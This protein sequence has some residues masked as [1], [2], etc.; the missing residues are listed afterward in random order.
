MNAFDSSSRSFTDKRT[1]MEQRSPRPSRLRPYFRKRFLVYAGVPLAVLA[2]LFAMRVYHPMASITVFTFEGYLTPELKAKFQREH[3]VRVI[4]RTFPSNQDMMAHLKVSWGEYDVVT[5]SNYV[6]NDLRRRQLVRRLDH[7]QLPNLRHLD[8]LLH[9]YF[10][11]DYMSYAVPYAWTSLSIAY[12]EG[13]VPNPPKTWSEFFAGPNGLSLPAAVLSEKRET[14]GVALVSLGYEPGTT[15]PAELAELRK[16]LLD[17]KDRGV[18]FSPSPIDE[19]LEGRAPLCLDWTS[20]ILR[21]MREDPTIRHVVPGG[22]TLLVLDNLVIPT[23]SRHPKLAEKFV[24]FLLR[25]DIAGE[26]AAESYFLTTVAS[27]YPIL[28][29]ELRNMIKAAFA[30]GRLVPLVGFGA[31][32]ERVYDVLWAEFNRHHD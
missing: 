2:G 23:S 11:D 22:P 31:N 10:K 5:A 1:V 16:L 18:L 17:F 20:N 21:G 28:P 8:P 30:E 4:E 27:A 9:R 24:N 3:H 12:R 32:D 7:K 25:P 26:H 6:M 29:D 19:L 14:M 15:K 13:A